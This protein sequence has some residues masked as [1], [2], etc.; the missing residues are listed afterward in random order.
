MLD[1]RET[2]CHDQSADWSR[3]DTKKES[4]SVSLKSLK[5]RRTDGSQRVVRAACKFL[6]SLR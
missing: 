1:K 6:Q 5:I 3:N 2:D 4:I